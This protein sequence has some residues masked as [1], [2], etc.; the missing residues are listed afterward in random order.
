M[1]EIK[2][3]NGCVVTCAS[4]ED[5]FVGIRKEDDKVNISF[6]M[7]FSL[8]DNSKQVK[9]DIRL[10]LKILAKAKK[11][12]S[13]RENITRRYDRE[14]IP[15]QAYIM[16]ITDFMDRGYYVEQEVT[17]KSSIHGKIDWRK[18]ISKQQVYVQDMDFYYLNFITKKSQINDNQLIT[19]IHEYCVYES[20]NKI[21]F[22]YS[23]FMPD[24]PRLSLQKKIFI[25]VLNDKISQTFND[26]NKQ[27]F[28]AML[29]II[30]QKDSGKEQFWYGTNHF[31]SIWE[32]MID[33]AFGIK[34]K[35]KYFPRTY[36]KT[37]GRVSEK[38]ALVPDTIMIWE[39]EIFILDAK[40]Y[41]YGI[42]QDV[43]KLPDSTSIH[44]QI[45]YGEYIE[46]NRKLDDLG[47]AVNIYNAFLIPYNSQCYSAEIVKNFGIAYSEWKNNNKTYET[48][49]G[50]FVDTRWLMENYQNTLDDIKNTLVDVIKNPCEMVCN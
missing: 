42:K 16:I 22:I 46:K 48:V 40:Y 9:K 29:A 39:K 45:T 17:Y 35:Q 26:R 49:Q 47:E 3:D 7:G 13:V 23:D 12:D 27:L 24:K 21:G 4:E 41:Q 5:L 33:N 1:N 31:H 50:I 8:S 20:F 25:K 15:I 18:T 19:L 38:H 32:T 36:W 14:T 30:Q 11:H 10:L 28:S 6:P 43:S 37:D 2:L 34:D 44:K